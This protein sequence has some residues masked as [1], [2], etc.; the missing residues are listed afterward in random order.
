VR[1]VCRYLS[2]DG[3]SGG[4]GTFLLCTFLLAEAQALAGDVAT[5]G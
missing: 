4:E 5:S 3:L 2:R 1:L